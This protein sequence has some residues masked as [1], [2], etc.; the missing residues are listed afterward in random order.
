MSIQIKDER[1]PT[2]SGILDQTMQPW[3]RKKTG[4]QVTL[5]YFAL[6]RL[7]SGSGSRIWVGSGTGYFFSVRVFLL[8]LRLNFDSGDMMYISIH[9]RIKELMANYN[10]KREH[11]SGQCWVYWGLIWIPPGCLGWRKFHQD[12]LHSGQE[13]TIWWG[14]PG[15]GC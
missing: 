8:Q 6:F 2:P 1:G 9:Q 5:L 14:S 3:K 7:R 12:M 4:S 11:W 15:S 13:I 10:D